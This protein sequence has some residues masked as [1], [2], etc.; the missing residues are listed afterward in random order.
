MLTGVVKFESEKR[1]VYKF[2]DLSV[3]TIANSNRIQYPWFRFHRLSGKGQGI[4]VDAN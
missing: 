4:E 2:T 3:I 1:R